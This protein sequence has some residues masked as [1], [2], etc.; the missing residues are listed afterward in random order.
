MSA[1]CLDSSPFHCIAIPHHTVAN[2]TI[3]SRTIQHYS[4][5]ERSPRAARRQATRE[6]FVISDRVRN[7]GAE[8]AE[9]TLPAGRKLRGSLRHE[10]RRTDRVSIFSTPPAAA[11]RAPH[12]QPPT[13]SFR[14]E[15]H[16]YGLT[17]EW[18]FSARTITRSHPRRQTGS[19]I[20]ASRRHRPI[21][22][23]RRPAHSLVGELGNLPAWS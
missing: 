20:I 5:L 12:G 19:S 6:P 9:Q 13:E 3:C 16:A 4:A 2:L 18:L 11:S 10:R 1:T 14:E 23:E 8:V 15:V 21:F 17:C 7:P 22:G